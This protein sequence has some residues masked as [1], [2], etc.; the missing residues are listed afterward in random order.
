MKDLYDPVWVT[1]VIS[2][3]SM[4][5]DLYLVDGSAGID[6]GYTMQANQIEPYE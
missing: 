3:Q 4:V 6:I 5:K 1:G 2:V